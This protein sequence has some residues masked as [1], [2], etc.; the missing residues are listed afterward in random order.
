MENESLGRSLCWHCQ[1]EV[2]GEYF[3]DQCVKIQPITPRVDYF[4]RLELPR[5]LTIDL[6][7]LE[8]RY[9]ELSRKFH[10]DFFQNKSEAEREISLKNSAVLN[11][12]YRTLRD[13]ILRVEYLISQEEGAVKE[14]PAKA[15]PDLLEEVLEIQEALEIFVQNPNDNPKLREDLIKE[16]DRIDSRKKALEGKLFGL[17]K[18]WDRLEERR[19]AGTEGSDEARRS[20]ISSMKDHLS[21][22][23]YLRTVLR[24]LE[25]GLKQKV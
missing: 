21:A 3:C 20:L 5:R 16:R 12:A 6:E 9:Y 17:F 8:R 10:P 7:D 14:I 18:E 11:T 4:D 13:P 1:S 19:A 15:P 23:A 25:E 2:G 22:R 24:G